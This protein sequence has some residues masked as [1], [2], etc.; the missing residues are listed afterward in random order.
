[1]KAIAC[2]AGLVT[3]AA[4]CGR[5]QG[6]MSGTVAGIKLDVNSVVYVDD[7][8]SN[9]NLVGIAVLLTD[10]P[11][12]CKTLQGGNVPQGMTSLS[13][14]LLRLDS[15]GKPL[16]PTVQAY[17]VFAPSDLPTM[18]GEYAVATFAHLDS[19]CKNT[20]TDAQSTGT[21]GAVR[22]NAITLEGSARG[23]FDVSVGSQSDEVSGS[24]DA[25]FCDVDLVASRGCS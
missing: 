24:F 20:L 10:Q 13:L 2:I 23:G 17:G 6:T 3:L 25:V 14:S 1:M 11:D 22:L 16:V 19:T 12:I 4:G 8:D 5:V 7:K 18:A 21:S 15:S 9:G